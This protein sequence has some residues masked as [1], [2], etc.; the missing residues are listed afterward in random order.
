[1]QHAL[2]GI[3]VVEPMHA[4]DEK[5]SNR[6]MSFLERL[7]KQLGL[8]SDEA[9]VSDPEPSPIPP[10]RAPSGPFHLRQT[11]G[12][13]ASNFHSVAWSPDGHH[14]AAGSD[15]RCVR[16]WSA[17]TGELEH[18]LEGHQSSVQSVA[19]S[20]DGTRLASGS[21]DQSVRVWE[22]SSGRALRTLE[23]HQR[24]VQSVAWS[25]D[26]TLLASGSADKSVRVWSTDTWSE[27]ASF[28]Q[29]SPKYFFL[30]VSWCPPTTVAAQF[31]DED[32]LVRSWD[33]TENVPLTPVSAPVSVHSTSAKIVFVGE[34]NVGKSCLA[35]RLAEDRYYEEQGST[36]GMK[37]WTL[38]PEQLDANVVTPPGEKR[39]VTLWDLG[40]QDE[41][42]LIHQLFLH[43]TTLA[44]VLFDPTR[45][46]TAFEEVE[47]WNLRLEKQLHGRQTVKLLVGTKLDGEHSPIDQAGLQRLIE[48]CKF[49]G[50][51]PTSAK[52]P[53]G[54]DELRAAMAQAIDWDHLAKTT[55]P[56]L[57]QKVRDEIET[58]RKQGEVV[59]LHA[60]LEQRLQHDDPDLYEQAAVETVVQQLTVVKST[61]SCKV[62]R[63]QTRHFC[64]IGARRSVVSSLPVRPT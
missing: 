59:L 36:L 19:W 12:W 2:S 8:S 51:F 34:S 56:V 48:T 21:W 49:D 10:T 4:M 46:R 57:F 16:V 11:F 17:T 24:E 18:L 61:G 63:Q 38:Q 44:L 26:G 55:R 42:R 33:C 50:Y 37:L 25:P 3:R 39:D 47:G 22:V 14:I 31:G 6:P 60:D 41:Y 35:L 53:R 1:M 58:R 15:D 40:G 20:P 9:S 30:D 13:P 52:T 29:P 64:G 43:D 45:G 28:P 7:K 32:M 27:L 62:V 23:G 5:G 54:M